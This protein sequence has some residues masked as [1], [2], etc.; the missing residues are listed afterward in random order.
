MHAE[1]APEVPK[2]IT[3]LATHHATSSSVRSRRA[4]YGVETQAGDLDIT[5]ALDHDNLLR[6]KASLEHL[7][8]RPS[9]AV[10]HWQGQPDGERKWLR[11]V[12]TPE[13][14]E[15]FREGWRL[16]PNDPDTVDQLFTTRYGNLAVV[17]ELVGSYDYLMERAVPRQAFGHKVWVAHVDDLLTTLTVPRREKDRARVGRLREVQLRRGRRTI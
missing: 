8:A 17:P 4:L 11:D 12:I 7:Q 3:V 14:I 2:L 15:A 16:E 1:R 6:L 13:E 9:S 10:G 5:P